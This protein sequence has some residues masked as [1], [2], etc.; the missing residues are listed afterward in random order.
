MRGILSL[1]YRNG[2]HRTKP[3]KPEDDP[4]LSVTGIRPDLPPAPEPDRRTA[5][6]NPE[7]AGASGGKKAKTAGDPE[8]G[9]AGPI[10]RITESIRDLAVRAEETIREFAGAVSGKG[11]A[12]D[13]EH[14][15][16]P[17][18]SPS[19]PPENAFPSE[20]QTFSPAESVEEGSVPP[21]ASREMPGAAA[22][23]GPD[24]LSAVPEFRAEVREEDI[25]YRR[26]GF[27][28]ETSGGCQE[29]IPQGSVRLLLDR[30][31][32]MEERLSL[33]NETADEI[34]KELTI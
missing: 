19:V 10:R 6:T 4:S 34:R 25:P 20:V 5:E 15:R 14:V 7:K 3:S 13:A 8:D 31:K 22:G 18:I 23:S 21:F 9:N 32:E 12:G 24:G 16:I 11:S 28:D 29:Q 2:K 26:G 1:F 30:T 27:T 33:L 17:R